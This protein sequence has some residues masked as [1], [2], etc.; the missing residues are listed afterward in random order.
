[1]NGA[2]ASGRR[3]LVL[4]A[5]E[6]QFEART[7]AACVAEYSDDFFNELRWRSDVFAYR[8]QDEI[9]VFPL[10]ENAELPDPLQELTTADHLHAL[11]ALLQHTLSGVLAQLELRRRRRP[12]ARLRRVN[13]ND[14][15]VVRSFEAMKREVPPEL[16]AFHKYL[17]SEFEVRVIEGDDHAPM[18]VIALTFQRQHE[19]DGSASELLAAG[20]DLRE[21]EV[22]DPDRSLPD[23]YL[24]TVLDARRDALLVRTSGGERELRA[25]QCVVEPSLRTFA[26]AFSDLLDSDWPRYQAAERRLLAQYTSGR[27]YSEHLRRSCD[28]LVRRGVVEVAPSL[29]CSFRGPV[30]VS[31]GSG[32]AAQTLEPVEYCFSTDLSKRH[33]YPAIGL[34]QFGPFDSQTFDKKRPRMLVV[35]PSQHQ[36]DVETFLRRLRDGMQNERVDRFRRGLVGTY[37]L[38]KLDLEWV[39]VS[40]PRDGASNAGDCYIEALKEKFNAENPPDVALVVLREL[41]AFA[42][43]NNAY[44]AS[45]A[46]LL[47]HGVPVQQVRLPTVRQHP[48]GLA[49]TLENIAVAL[50][51]KLGG[52][53]W[54]VSPT[55]P[56]AEEIVIGVGVAESG[57]RFESRQRYAGITTVFRSDGSYVLAAA[58]ERC[59]YSEFPEVLIGFVQRT[60]RRLAVDRGWSPGDHVRLVFHSHQP[61]KKTDIFRLVEKAVGELGGGIHFQTAFLTVRNEHPFKVVD[62]DEQ[63]RERGGI[64]LIDGGF[65]KKLVGAQVPARG[66]VVELGPTKQLLC[67]TG[68]ALVKREG[69][70]VPDPLLIEL[71]PASTYRD[72][73]SLVR[74]VF[75]FTGLS[76][77]SMLPVTEPVT[78]FYSHLI[79]SNLVKLEHVPNWVDSLLDTRLRRSRWFL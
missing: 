62:P 18:L 61:L 69:E 43:D 66:T 76:W 9:I 33:Q 26:F 63:G 11:G 37:R 6:V 3:K 15:L 36:G 24:G 55:M 1:M 68:A 75:H 59:K 4:S 16:R 49:Y 52:A 30:S 25:D 70:P 65:G 21:M 12:R 44:L 17:R 57:G 27:G 47:S 77:R 46:F 23:R 53:P 22:L 48:R 29:R 14:D 2:T 45:K 20:L 56:V 50:Y 38:S 54:T 51:A 39:L 67:V 8:S 19:I 41:D 60:L 13:R 5:V 40:L 73:D 32:G 64:K 10:Q 31:F 34:D 28:Y 74:Q 71:H 35:A 79:A 58:S 42:P 7:F 78:I 72:L